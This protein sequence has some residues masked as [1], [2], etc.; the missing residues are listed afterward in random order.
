MA[1][2]YFFGYFTFVKPISRLAAAALRVGEG[3][4]GTRTGLPHAPNELGRLTKSFDDMASLLEARDVK[5]KLAEA[6]LQESNARIG[7][8][9]DV[10]RAIR[11]VGSL[12]NTEKDPIELLKRG[13]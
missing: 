4:M 8:L 7:H 2:A 9:N 10:L 11:D 12:I 6:S 1:L 5:R 13:L 3:E